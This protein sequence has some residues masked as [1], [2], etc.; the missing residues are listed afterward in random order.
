MSTLSSGDDFIFAEG[1]GNSAL[2]GKQFQ[3][4]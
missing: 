1:S 4:A 2:E 3:S